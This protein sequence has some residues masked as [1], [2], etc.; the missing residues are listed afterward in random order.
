[1]SG[2]E[3][4]S[5]TT[6]LLQ[7]ALATARLNR[8]KSL[9]LKAG[10][11]VTR[12]YSK[13]ESSRLPLCSRTCKVTVITTLQCFHFRLRGLLASCFWAVGPHTAR[14]PQTSPEVPRMSKTSS[15]RQAGCTSAMQGCPLPLLRACLSRE[16][17]LGICKTM[18]SPE[19]EAAIKK[20]CSCSEGATINTTLEKGYYCYISL[21]MKVALW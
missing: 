9:H 18:K 15:L 8:L 21:Q 6:R 4:I 17:K 20:P 16:R 7:Q 12:N 1:M 10:V 13:D 11:Q 3:R 5:A 19:V 2:H 14:D